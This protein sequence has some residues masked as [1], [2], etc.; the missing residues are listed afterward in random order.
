[1]K[2]GSWSGISSSSHET[3]LLFLLNDLSKTLLVSQPLC[4]PRSTLNHYNGSEESDG[5]VRRKSSFIQT[6]SISPI[7]NNVHF[8][9][10]KCVEVEKFSILK[11][12]LLFEWGL[13]QKHCSFMCPQFLFLFLLYLCCWRF[14]MQYWFQW[15]Y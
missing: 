11:K 7:D 15:W 13:L 10:R 5:G 6:H 9:H 1:M 4:D 3:M 2:Y 8:V 12:V 14:S